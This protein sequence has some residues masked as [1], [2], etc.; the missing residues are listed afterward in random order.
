MDDPTKMFIFVIL[1]PLA[2]L[3]LAQIVL[4]FLSYKL[5]WNLVPRG[6]QDIIDIKSIWF[7]ICA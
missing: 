3:G 1:I 6:T 4:E 2:A 5:I 7:I